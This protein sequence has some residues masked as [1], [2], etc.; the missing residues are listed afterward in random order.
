MQ[1]CRYCSYAALE[2]I[3]QYTYAYFC[4]AEAD[5]CRS[6]CFCSWHTAA[7]HKLAATRHRHKREDNFEELV[8]ILS[9]RLQSSSLSSCLQSVS[10]QEQLTLLNSIALTTYQ[11]EVLIGTLLGDAHLERNK[12]SHNARLRFDHTYPEHKDCQ[13]DHV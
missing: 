3:V 1:C 4:A 5:S 7:L 13:T 6:A 11:K 8:C 9:T 12:L 10:L 2:E